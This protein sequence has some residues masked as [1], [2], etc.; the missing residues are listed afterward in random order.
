MRPFHAPIP[1]PAPASQEYDDAGPSRTSGRYDEAE[2][3]EAHSGE[4][5]EDGP[6]K[7]HWRLTVSE[8]YR[9]QFTHHFQPVPEVDSSSWPAEV[10]IGHIHLNSEPDSI[11]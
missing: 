3:D 9:D 2:R 1:V 11:I 6:T 10:N 8:I 4:R 7:E 5:S